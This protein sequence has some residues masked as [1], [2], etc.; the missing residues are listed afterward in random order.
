MRYIRMYMGG[1][2]GEPGLTLYEID[3][4]GWVHRQVQI[5]AEGSRFSP[6]DILM[7]RAVSTDY[8]AAHPTAEEIDEDVFED[9]WAE[10]AECRS[11]HRRVPNPELPW[12]GWLEQLEHTVELQWLPH[13]DPQAGWMLVPGFRHLYVR[14][15]EDLA[16]AAQRAVFLERP[17]HWRALQSH[18]AA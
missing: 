2:D 8:M 16:W 9:L 1:E 17:I 15:D 5:H 3:A 12:S 18:A 13:E 7:R 14:G 11:F 6:E 4:N 10:V